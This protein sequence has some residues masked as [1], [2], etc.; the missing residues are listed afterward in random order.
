MTIER[1]RLFHLTA[2]S[3]PISLPALFWSRLLEEADD[4]LHE[5]YL[6]HSPTPWRER[7]N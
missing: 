2:L 4:V 7:E 1:L 3:T 6:R 5:G